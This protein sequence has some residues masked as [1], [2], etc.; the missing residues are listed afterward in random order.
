MPEPLK[1]LEL[2]AAIGRQIAAAR[3]RVHPRPI[4][5][6]ELA[7]RV[8]LARGSIANIE[9]GRQ[10]PPL[11]TLY[12]I[13]RALGV[14]PRQL[15]PSLADLDADGPRSIDVDGVPGPVLEQ[16][17]ALGI[18]GREIIAYIGEAKERLARA[19]REGDG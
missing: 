11:D 5:Q 19:P 12:R 16:I 9:R 3:L 7:T 17:E 13:A 10:R 15:L 4:S 1:V 18:E 6:T 8:Q 2:Y 14:E